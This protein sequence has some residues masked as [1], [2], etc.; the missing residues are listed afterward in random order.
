MV[1][2]NTPGATPITANAR[3]QT[4]A[5]GGVRLAPER[6]T[7]LI[8]FV[9][10]MVKAPPHTDKLAG[11]AMSP[12]GRVSV[13]PTPVRATVGFG[14]RTVN[15]SV[16]TWFSG[17]DA[18]VNFLVIDGGPTTVS[19]ATTGAP[20][21]CSAEVT[22]DVTF[23]YSVATELVTLRL[24]EHVAPPARLAPVKLI[25]PP[26]AGALIVPPPHE[27]VSPLGVATNRFAG[28]VSENP[29]PVST[30]EVLGFLTVKLRTDVP[31]TRI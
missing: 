14:L 11:G 8:L 1:L 30:R 12:L 16:A 26:P 21:P 23:G 10:V 6:V 4:L 5:A 29:M 20:W 15:D 17:I 24:K 9:V 25:D 27:P 22:V 13:N 18:G 7:V 31:F 19:A 2:V 28:K 3:G